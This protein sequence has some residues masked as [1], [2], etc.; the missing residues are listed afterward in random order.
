M[1]KQLYSV[2]CCATIAS[3]M[4]FSNLMGNL[5]FFEETCMAKKRPFL[6]PLLNSIVLCN[7]N[8]YCLTCFLRDATKVTRVCIKY[9]SPCLDNNLLC[10]LFASV[11]D[12]LNYTQTTL[13]YLKK[14]IK[15]STFDRLHIICKSNANCDNFYT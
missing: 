9:G 5:K 6:H 4:E 10:N 15:H 14:S 1:C 13:R 7:S 2:W 8:Y 11:W 3:C 12:A